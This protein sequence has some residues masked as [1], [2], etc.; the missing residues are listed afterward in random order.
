MLASYL[1]TY[2]LSAAHSGGRWLL[3]VGKTLRRKGKGCWRMGGVKEKKG[4][5]RARLGV[6]IVRKILTVHTPTI[7]SHLLSTFVNFLFS[8]SLSLKLHFGEEFGTLA[9]FFGRTK[10]REVFW[11]AEKHQISF[12][13]CD[14][15]IL[16][17]NGYS[18]GPS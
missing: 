18:F 12:L 3:V 17:R 4:G 15:L 10:S 2:I 16:G 13:G 5:W 7:S 14:L 6:D 9:T 11:I 1:T 8:P